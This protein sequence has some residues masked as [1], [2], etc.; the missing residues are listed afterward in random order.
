[1]RGIYELKNVTG[2]GAPYEVPTSAE[3]IIDTERL[4]PDQALTHVLERLS[5]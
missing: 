3:I 2:L 1:M 4:D 5:R